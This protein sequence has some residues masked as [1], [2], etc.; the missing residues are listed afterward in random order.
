[1]VVWNRA[2]SVSDGKWR[3]LDSR[4][5]FK[6]P[7]AL[8]RAA[9]GRPVRPAHRARSGS[10]WDGRARRHSAAAPLGDHRRPRAADGRV[11][12]S[13]PS[14]SKPQGRPD[15]AS[16][17]AAHGRQPTGV[18]IVRL[19]QQATL[20]TRPDKTHRSLAEMTDDWRQ[21]APRAYVGDAT[22]VGRGWPSLAGPQRPAAPATS[23]IWPTRS[24]PTPPAPSCTTVADGGP[25]SPGPTCSPRPTA[26]STG[27]ASPP[28]TSGS[29]SPNGSPTSPSGRSLL[30]TPPELHHTPER[31]S[32]PTGPRGSDPEATRSTPPRRS[33]TP[34]PGCS[35]PAAELA[36]P[37][38]HGRH[39]RGGRRSAPARQ[40]HRLSSTRPSR[41]S[42]SPPPGG[43]L[44]VLVGPAGTGKSTAMAALRAVWEAE[45][46]PGS[47]IGLAPSA[48]AA[49]VLADELGIDTE[50][51]A[52]W[53]TEHRRAARPTRRQ[54]QPTRSRPGRPP[55][56][57]RSTAAAAARPARPSST[58]E[59][60]P[61]A[62]PS[63]ASWSSSTRPA[64]PAP[65][66]STSSS[67]PP[68]TPAPRS[69][70]VGD[71][72]QLSAVDAGGHVRA[73]RP[74]TAATSSPSSSDVRRFQPRLGEGRP[75]S[76][77]AAATTTAI[78]AYQAHGRIVDGGR[79]ELLDAALPGLEGRHR[80][81]PDQ[82]DDRRRPATVTEL[83][84]RARADRIAAGQVD[85]RRA[86]TVA[87][88]PDRRGRR[89]GRHPP[90]RP[91]PRHR[92]AVGQKRR[93]LDRHRHQTTMA[94]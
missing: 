1:M 70:L 21:Q 59:V 16:S 93:P 85:R 46:G 81:R 12:A 71:W 24:W 27:S 64:W 15:R 9:P 68:P 67:P 61:L 38:R 88:G 26:S 39:G 36:R 82:P 83:N 57:D 22:P 91:S 58:A 17:S 45:H 54:R 86:S 19:R 18:E 42:R 87:G 92:P 4:G 77:S 7:S 53:L 56:P 43:R 3:T 11:L 10:G 14:Q 65:S 50:N 75:A 80:R 94:P 78:D 6:A 37:D 32:A 33:S 44:D 60:A 79:D 29:P 2:R 51:T 8:S 47:V 25:R 69:L 73:A 20:A 30:L 63:P 40:D 62:A 41:S 76:T 34:R 74:P 52:K 55:R 31:S 89:P 66:P 49:E 28:P 5:L 13:G 48:A 90:E 23:A 35:T 84:R 72:A